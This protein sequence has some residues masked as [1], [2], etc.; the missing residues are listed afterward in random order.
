MT[1]SLRF[2]AIS[3]LFVVGAC[4]RAQTASGTF[5]RTLNVAEP[6]EL[7]V[8]TGSG[9]ID[10]R[11]GAAGKVEVHGEIRVGGWK[12]SGVDEIVKKIEA[13]PPIELDGN[14]LRIGRLDEGL[15]QKN[16]SISYTIVVPAATQLRSHTGSGSQ[17][18]SGLAG[19]VVVESGSGSVTLTDIG[20]AAEARTGSGSIHAHGIGGAFTGAAGSGRIEVALTGRG[21]VA[22]ST[23][24]GSVELTGV[25]GAA[26][27]RTGSGSLSVEGKPTGP[28]EL[29]TGSGSAHARVA[30]D[31]A[32]T[33]DAKAG[34]G[35][36][37]TSQAVTIVGGTQ[38]GE[39]QGQVRGGGPTVRIRTGSGG[40]NID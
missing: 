29:D 15:W 20:G 35:G 10:I 34:S 39:L 27:V 3:V 36:V 37:R 8:Q 7:D 6:L 31:A 28:W 38:R 9:S 33:I 26:R 22:V 23:G 18:A 13:S 25:D 17:A 32:F 2:L 24:S 21:D 4:A 14:R 16:V 40:I 12:I 1:S 11:A 5:D 19:P 30:S